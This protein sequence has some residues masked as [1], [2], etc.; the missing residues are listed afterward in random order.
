MRSINQDVEYLWLILIIAIGLALR[1]AAIGAFSHTPGS[2]EIAYQTMALNLVRGNGIVDSMGNLAMYNMGY[3]SFVLAPVFALFG[4][5]ILIARILNALLGGLAIVL[6]YA[7]A[8]EAGAGQIGR[9]FAAAMWALYIPACVSVVYLL[10]ENLM[11]PLM[12]GVLWCALRVAKEPTCRTG[13]T[14]GG[15]FGFL[16]L[17]G[18]A[19]LSLSAPVLFA[20]MSAPVDLS[21]KLSLS[22]GIFLSAVL[23]TA[24]WMVRNMQALG[25]PALNTISGRGPTASG[26]TGRSHA[27]RHAI[28]TQIFNWLRQVGE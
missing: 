26:G 9:L 25:T 6:C 1:A 13:L 7:C 28:A 17:T 11:I 8:K 12:L 22:V 14:C 10:K 21:R 19:A 27:I 20:L 16:A 4:E 3:P 24:P 2:D 18:N 5:N 23:I 15:L